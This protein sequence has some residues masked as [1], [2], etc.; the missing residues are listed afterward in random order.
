MKADL[1]ES[2]SDFGNV[3][4]RHCGAFTSRDDLH[5]GK[6]VGP[7]LACFDAQQDFTAAGLNRTRCHVLA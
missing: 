5:P 1:L 7:L 3:A 6:L 2:I 4:E